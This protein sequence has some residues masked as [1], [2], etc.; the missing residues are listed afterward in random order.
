MIQ[1]KGLTKLYGEF[2]AVNELDL[3]VQPG[4]VMGLVGP[5]GA[6]KT[7]TLRCLSGI[8]PPTRGSIRICGHDLANDPIAAKQ[9]LAFFTDEPRLFD[10]LTVQQHL[11]FTARIYQV[12]HYEPLTHQLLE[13]LELAGKKNAV[14]GELSR[15]MKQKLAIACGLLHA[16]RVIYFDEP[17]TGLDPIGIRRMKDSIIKRARD[18]AAIIIS[19]HLLHLVEEICSHIL[20]LKEGRKIIQ[21]TLAEIT[22]KFAAQ[23]GDAS[24]EE[25]F[26]RAT[27]D[28]DKGEG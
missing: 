4:E 15:G 22:Q 21:G 6:G 2:V 13:E 16:P 20:I 10:Y 12:E 7:T 19:S 5:N 14:P 8:I 11:A 1:V 18:G 26:F 25:V 9:Q 28:A 3:E 17:L 27:G 23:A 24:L